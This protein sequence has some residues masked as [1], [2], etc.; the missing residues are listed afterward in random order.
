MLNLIELKCTN[1]FT[2]S[3]VLQHFYWFKSILKCALCSV[4]YA[5]YV[6]CNVHCTLYS[7]QC[8]GGQ[9]PVIKFGISSA[10]RSLPQTNSPTLTS[11]SLDPFL[12]QIHH[13]HFLQL[14]PITTFY[15]S[16]G[17]KFQ[18]YLIFVTDWFCIKLSCRFKVFQIESK[19]CIFNSSCFLASQDALEV[20]LV[21][22]Y[23]PLYMNLISIVNECCNDITTLIDNVKKIV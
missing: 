15:Y 16:G 19:K 23:M 21:W 1:H 10:G 11:H 18:P 14:S 3:A 9:S 22:L 4:G 8:L 2:V 13:L 20:M 5:V 12:G 7:V 17:H 6:V